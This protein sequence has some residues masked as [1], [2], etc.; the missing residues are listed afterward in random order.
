MVLPCH[1]IASDDIPQADIAFAAILARIC[2]FPGRAASRARGRA[3]ATR[4]GPDDQ[5]PRLT[6]PS[7][8]V[9]R[10]AAARIRERTSVR[11]GIS[12]HSRPADPAVEPRRGLVCDGQLRARRDG[13]NVG[14][15]SCR[16]RHELF[17]QPGGQVRHA[18][19]MSQI[20]RGDTHAQIGLDH[21][22]DADH[23][24]GAAPGCFAPRSTRRPGGNGYG[25]G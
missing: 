25:P 10:S 21:M 19:G 15:R 1:C 4:A 5:P 24:P 3:A 8:V 14:P 18:G 13:A 22:P 6:M 16:R 7:T 23:G 9:L 2:G 11:G 17:I 12:R 20:H